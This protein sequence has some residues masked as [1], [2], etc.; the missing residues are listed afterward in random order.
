MAAILAGR[1]GA[2]LIR[3]LA[4]EEFRRLDRGPQ[5]RVERPSLHDNRLIVERRS[6]HSALRAPVET[7]E[8]IAL[9]LRRDPHEASLHRRRRWDIE[10]PGRRV[11]RTEIGRAHV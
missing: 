11:R 3:A 2:E 7:T 10:C 5:G 6:L 9:E 1:L 8:A 4:Y